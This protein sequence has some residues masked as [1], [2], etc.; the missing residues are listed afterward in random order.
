VTKDL[1]HSV[2]RRPITLELVNDMAARIASARASEEGKE[3]VRAF[4]EKRPPAWLREANQLEDTGA[5]RK[6]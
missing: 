3:G 1:I 5:R 4:F 2:V 6:K